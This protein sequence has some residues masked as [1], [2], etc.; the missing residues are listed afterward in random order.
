MDVSSSSGGSDDA[1][2]AVVLLKSSAELASATGVAAQRAAELVQACTRSDPAVAILVAGYSLCFCLVMLYMYERGFWHR[3]RKAESVYM[4]TVMMLIPIT[5]IVT[6]FGQYKLCFFQT[7]S[8]DLAD[9]LFRQ[10]VQMLLIFQIQ[11]WFW[12]KMHPS[13]FDGRLCYV[14][15]KKAKVAGALARHVEVVLEGVMEQSPVLVSQGILSPLLLGISMMEQFLW[16]LKAS[17]ESQLSVILGYVS[18]A[19]LIVSL[20]NMAHRVTSSAAAVERL[21]TIFK[22]LLISGDRESLEY[23]LMTISVPTLLEVGG[24][25]LVGLLTDLALEQKMLTTL[26]KAILV[27]ALQVRGVSFCVDSQIALMRLLRSVKGIEL[28]ALKNLIDGSG[29]YHNLY[30]LVYFDLTSDYLRE[31]LLEH[32]HNEGMAL[33]ASLSGSA[34]IKILSDIDDT[35]YSSGGTFPA[36]CDRR[37]PKGMVYPGCLEL[38]RL[39]DSKTNVEE[40]LQETLGLKGMVSC[41]LVFV[42]ARPHLF[43]DI[44]ERKSY[45]FFWHLVRE[46]RMHMLPT[47]LPGHLKP[48]MKALMSYGCRGT[49]AWRA[50]GEVKV[51][52]FL[53][54]RVLYPEYDFIFCGD[55]GQGDL[56]AAQLMLNPQ[57]ARIQSAVRCC[58]RRTFRSPSSC[59]KDDNVEHLD[60]REA[61]CSS[62][63]MSDDSSSSSLDKS[64]GQVLA[65]FIHEVLPEGTAALAVDPPDQRG[66]AWRQRLQ[67]QGILFHRSYVGA[68]VALHRRCPH[69][70]GAADVSTIAEQ[71]TRE[72]QSE[73]QP[74]VKDGGDLDNGET[75]F[76]SGEQ[77]LR[78]DLDDANKVIAYAGLPAVGHLTFS[79]Q[80]T[81]QLNFDA[82]GILVPI[83]SD[84][85]PGIGEEDTANESDRRGGVESHGT[86]RRRVSF[87]GYAVHH[88]VS[89]SR[90]PCRLRT[91]SE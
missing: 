4:M 24:N 3:S 90:K 71:A 73:W 63:S 42:S 87:A 30:K 85:D 7:R 9:N 23:V 18:V 43:K 50:V 31:S 5:N 27:N 39:L 15:L 57:Q 53:Q 83:R 74:F 29:N 88:H 17:H 25:R 34:G 52:A 40:L 47:L 76:S 72:C 26:T 14:K 35:L 45:R 65:C 62:D 36:G 75:V 12:P 77:D 64:H 51:D 46:Q 70:F 6:N 59:C 22:N 33:R 44:A 10:V 56:Y 58:C 16:T 89:P 38:F 13:F 54:F 41:N 8:W 86:S 28:T 67:Q 69:L 19:L 78:S 55:N 11:T 91:A 84:D 60:E 61:M 32:L 82:D 79:S 80:D 66:E 1:V 49:W 21:T 2:P 48:G 68:A 20:M 37:F 81:N